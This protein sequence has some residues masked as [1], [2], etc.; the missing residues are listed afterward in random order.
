MYFKEKID[1]FKDY[2]T[3]PG[4]ARKMVYQSSNS[5]FALFNKGNADLYYSFR[6]NIVGSPRIIFSEYHERDVTFKKTDNK[7]NVV[8]GYDC[9]G[10][11]SYAITQKM[12]TGVYVGRN[13]HNNCRP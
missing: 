8:V 2:I 3:L 7:Y 4:V 10:L 13:F 6:Q 5:K 12:P 11:Y 9:N 1:I